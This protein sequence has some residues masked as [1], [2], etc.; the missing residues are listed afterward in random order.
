V[1]IRLP[2]RAGEAGDGRRLGMESGENQQR[3]MGVLS[4]GVGFGD[5]GKGVDEGG[6]SMR[7]PELS[8]EFGRGGLS[9]DAGARRG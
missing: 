1:W 7:L 3:L 5:V 6:W 9:A 2:G 4:A 8:L